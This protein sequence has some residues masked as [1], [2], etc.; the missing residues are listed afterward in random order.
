MATINI[1][2]AGLKGVVKGGYVG[3]D[4]MRKI[5]DLS[6]IPLPLT[7]SIGTE[8]SK[9]SYK[10]WIVDDLGTPD[11]TTNVL[12]D[13]QDASSYMAITGERQGNH[14]QQTG[15]TVKVSDRAQS[16]DVIGRADILGDQLT[17][18]QQRIKRD[19]E[20][21]LLYNQASVADDGSTTAG[22]SAGLPAW[23]KSNVYNGSGGSVG[24]FNTTTGITAARTVATARSALTEAHLK[25][26]M[27][28][29]YG[30]GGDPK[31]VMSM[32]A[33]IR[34]MSEYYFAATTVAKINSFVDQTSEAAAAVA[35][36]S[37]IATDF[38]KVRLVPNR[39][40]VGHNDG[41]AAACAD[42]F[43]LDPSKLAISYFSGVNAKPLARTGTA[44][45][46]QVYADWTLMVMNEK[47]QGYIGDVNYA[48][49]MTG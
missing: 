41:S 17:R 35:A 49:A 24:G 2:S 23:I 36:V 42:L 20:A 9:N 8:K 32:P 18:A 43:V 48:T 14:H 5:W 21:T 3:E 11:P 34:L 38:G 31:V 25:T 19:I 39:L 44:D 47:A 1:N 28:G 27:Q 29:I 10:E 16:S 33:V 6:K 7:D 4:V 37:V 30:Y 15:R 13:G 45:N 22:K 12:I 26:I 40:Q 46:Y